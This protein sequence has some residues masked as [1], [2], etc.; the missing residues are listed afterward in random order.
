MEHNETQFPLFASLFGDHSVRNIAKQLDQIYPGRSFYSKL[1]A[2]EVRAAFEANNAFDEKAKAL[3]LDLQLVEAPTTLEGTTDDEILPTLFLRVFE[4]HSASNLAAIAKQLDQVQPGRGFHSMLLT[5]KLRKLLEEHQAD[6]SLSQHMLQSLME[7]LHT[8]NAVQ[9]V[10]PQGQ[11]ARPSVSPIPSPT[12]AGMATET[13][14]AM[15]IADY[16]LAMVVQN[17]GIRAWLEECK[18]DHSDLAFEGLAPALAD[19]TTVTESAGAGLVWKLGDLKFVK[20]LGN[21]NFGIVFKAIVDKYP[22][23]SAAVKFEYFLPKEFVSYF[24]RVIWCQ[25]SVVD[26][27]VVQVLGWFPVHIQNDD[28]S[29]Q[30]SMVIALILEECSSITLKK[31]IEEPGILGIPSYKKDLWII[32]VMQHVLAGLLACADKDVVHRDL[33]PGNV[34]LGKDQKTWKIGEFGL[35]RLAVSD[36]D[37]TFEAGTK[38]FMAPETFT[39]CYSSQSDLYSAGVILLLLLTNGAQPPKKSNY[40]FFESYDFRDL[41]SSVMVTNV[42]HRLVRLCEKM[43]NLDPKTRIEVVA[44]KAELDEIFVHAS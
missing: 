21:G 10:L 14:T 9:F 7:K 37:G 27:N 15:P 22:M 26:K 44:A 43:V 6:D 24:A 13:G 3:L 23:F 4:D 36:N 29:A 31:A 34:Y 20:P 17:V 41:F 35:A 11:D 42:R 39:G 12:A 30:T 2:S 38:E 1:V 19:K 16:S 32:N 5:S 25:S 33:K 28:E 8:D 18:F 40:R